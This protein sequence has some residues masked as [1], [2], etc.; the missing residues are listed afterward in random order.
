MTP[1][2]QAAEPPASGATVRRVPWL[3]ALGYLLLAVWVTWPLL[4]DGADHLYGIDPVRL[5]AVAPLGMADHYLNLWILSWDWHALTT[6]PLGLFDATIFHPLPHS[7]ATGEHMLGSV[8]WFAP[9]YATTGNAIA[10]ANTL[11][12][13]S[14]VIAGLGTYLLVLDV[15]GRRAAAFAAGMVFAFAPWRT[16]WLVH[17]QLVGVHLFPLVVFWLRRALETCSRRAV[18]AFAMA[19][20]LQMLTSYYLAYMC[21][22]LIGGMLV[23]LWRP[24]GTTRPTVA[25]FATVAAAALAAA[26]VLGGLSFPYVD[27]AAQGILP[28]GETAHDLE[29]LRLAAAQPAEFLVRGSP[30]YAGLLPSALALIGLIPYRGARRMQLFLLWTLGAGVLLSLGPELGGRSLPYAWLA[31]VVPGFSTLRVPERFLILATVGLAGLAGIGMAHLQNTFARLRT[32]RPARTMFALATAALLLLLGLDW[33]PRQ[34]DLV[35]RRFPRLAEAPPVYRFLATRGGSGAVLEVPPGGGGFAGAEMQARA[36]Y[37]GILHGLPLLGGYN[38]YIPPLA[39]LYGDLA[40]Q[41]PERETTQTFANIVDIGWIVV[42]TGALPPPLRTLWRRPP[43]GLDLVYG[44]EDDLLFRVRLPPAPDW[45]AHLKAP[46]PERGTFSG[47]PIGPVPPAGRRAVVRAAAGRTRVPSRALV[48]I[49][50]HIEN[51][52]ALPWPCFAVGEHGLVRAWAAWL[53]AGGTPEEQPVAARI[54]RDL[55]PG[56][57][58]ETWMPV[59]A[60]REAGTHELEISIGQGAPGSMDAW[61]AG[62]TRLRIEVAGPAR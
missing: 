28:S 31:A 12:F 17:L 27:L 30:Q 60:P 55:E 32:D 10:A 33:V 4:R 11:V 45:R 21:A 23:W 16:A 57:S 52:T 20:T 39:H 2:V 50:L 36:Q 43:D 26:A 58:V 62:A 51:P 47:L 41:L 37:F 42:H 1:G 8:P 19:L 7:L 59:W 44:F 29:R 38:G 14:F 46:G 18:A 35:L 15:T 6:H 49:D 34:S 22:V 5:P 53:D 61:R 9:V 54:P 56:S 25:R 48:R 3:A 40:R 24:R 13:V